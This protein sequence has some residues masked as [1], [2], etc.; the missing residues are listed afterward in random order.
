M[1]SLSFA[2]IGFEL[3]QYNVDERAEAYQLTVKILTPVS[4]LHSNVTVRVAAVPG[5]A[6]SEYLDKLD[7]I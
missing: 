2:V 3:E 6:T 4:S 7:T 1:L 5:N